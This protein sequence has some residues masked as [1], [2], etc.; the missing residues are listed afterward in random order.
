MTIRTQIALLKEIYDDRM[1]DA[2]IRLNVADMLTD[3]DIDTNWIYDEML[4]VDIPGTDDVLK[5]IISL[6][7]SV[8]MATE[9]EEYILNNSKDE[10]RGS[11]E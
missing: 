9:M 1:F 6:K 10:Q 3:C 4:R 7:K 5:R 2:Q 8:G 11:S